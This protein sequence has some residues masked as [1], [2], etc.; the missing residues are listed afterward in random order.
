MLSIERDLKGD[1]AIKAAEG[2][3]GEFNGEGER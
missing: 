2:N 3:E 1:W